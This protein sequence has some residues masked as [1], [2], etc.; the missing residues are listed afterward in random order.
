M[1]AGDGRPS[2][3]A[4]HGSSTG[5][6][7]SR[8][9][10]ACGRRSPRASRGARH[11]VGAGAERMAMA[12]IVRRRRAQQQFGIGME[13][14]GEDGLPG[15]VSTILPRY[16]TA[17]RCA[18]VL[19]DAEI[20]RDEEV[21]QAELALQ[22]AEQVED[23][24]LHRDVERRDRLVADDD[25]GLERERAGDADALALAAG[26]LVRKVVA[27][28]RAAA[29]R[30]PSAS[31]TS[32]RR[33]RRR[34]DAVD[35]ERRADDVAHALARIERGERILEDDLHAPR[36]RRAARVRPKPRDV[37]ALEARSARCRLDAGPSARGRS[38]TC[39]SRI[40]PT[41][42]ERLAA[43][44]READAVDRLAR[45]RPAAGA[46]RARIGKCTF[47]SSTR[48]QRCLTVS[49]S[50]CSQQAA[51][52]PAPLLVERRALREAARRWRAGSAARRRSP[53]GRS[54]S[55]GTVPGMSASRSPRRARRSERGDRAHQAERVG[56]ERV[57]EELVDAAPPRPGGRHT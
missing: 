50:A 38:S 53:C 34:A 31:A 11:V 3:A 32:S 1:M 48:K 56:M 46:R 10:S 19:D 29:R 44:E 24:R 23:L 14:R 27:P 51:K 25:L 39:R 12:R 7:R 42:A 37:R 52:W 45:C 30:A 16:I 21:G 41:S 17:T 57:V 36:D 49:A 40:S 33:S 9:G 55:G 2:S 15:P 18:D 26:E 20:V 28:G 13:W 5:R 22:V 8:A 35:V 6:R 43:A 47:R 4:Q 54:Q